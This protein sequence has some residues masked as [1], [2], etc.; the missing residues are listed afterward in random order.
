MTTYNFNGRLFCVKREHL[1]QRE[2]RIYDL[3]VEDYDERI[4]YPYEV[5]T[6][7]GS[8][9]TRWRHLITDE[10]TAL[11]DKSDER[12]LVQRV[13]WSDE[14]GDENLTVKRIAPMAHFT[15]TCTLLDEGMQV[16][17]FDVYLPVEDFVALMLRIMDSPSYG[18]FNLQMQHPVTY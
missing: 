1:L 8:L 3:L 13:D 9:A 12:P 14:I 16:M 11:L 7:D 6:S 5:E 15:L 2:Q 4:V 18:L 10:V 17:P